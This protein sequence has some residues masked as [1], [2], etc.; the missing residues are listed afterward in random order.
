MHA[1]QHGLHLCS[2]FCALPHLKA[3]V[4]LDHC[5]TADSS[6]CVCVLTCSLTGKYWLNSAESG[7]CPAS[8]AYCCSRLP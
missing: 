6:A 3:L 5:S 4:Y 7:S 8:S 1:V 2:T